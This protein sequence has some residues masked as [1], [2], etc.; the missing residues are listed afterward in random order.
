MAIV[1]YYLLGNE[2][3]GNASIMIYNKHIEC[4]GV[5]TKE[6][7]EQAKTNTCRMLPAGIENIAQM[8]K[9]VLKAN[10]IKKA[11]ECGMSREDSVIDGMADSMIVQMMGSRDTPQ[12]YV[13]TNNINYYGAACMLYDGVLKE[14]AKDRESGLYI[15]PSS[16]HETILIPDMDCDD[17]VFLN[18][19][20]SEVNATQLSP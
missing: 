2:E 3:F 14:F 11:Q 1:F 6:L 15:L 8:M 13:L 7:Y 19:I 20:L 10:I 12:L 9:N 16:V 18:T 5:S 4:W 17:V